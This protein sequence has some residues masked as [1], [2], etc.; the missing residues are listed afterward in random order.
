M[1]LPYPVRLGSVICR[2]VGGAFMFLA[3]PAGK[4]E[5]IFIKARNPLLWDYVV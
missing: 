3:S 2:R 1:G 4:E 5:G